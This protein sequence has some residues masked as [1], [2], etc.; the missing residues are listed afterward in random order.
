[1]R[2]HSLP[3]FYAV[4]LVYVNIIVY[5]FEK[6]IIKNTSIFDGISF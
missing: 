6:K 3:F 1:M 5:N 4:M 2:Q